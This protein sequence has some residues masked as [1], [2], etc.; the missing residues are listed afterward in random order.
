MKRIGN[1]YFHG[2]RNKKEIALTFDD[3]PSKQTLEILNI[4]KKYDVKA[5]FFIC[6]KKIKFEKWKEDRWS[7]KKNIILIGNYH[8]PKSKILTSIIHESIHINTSPLRMNYN[9]N[10]LAVEIATCIVT[11]III[12]RLNKKFKKKFKMNKFDEHYQK[13][14]KKSRKFERKKSGKNFY[15]FFKLIKEEI[16]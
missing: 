3:G 14:E 4:L 11:S 10:P 13:F 7:Y 12:K 8:K 6:G 15:E 5:T 9:K 2:N 16:K 1:L